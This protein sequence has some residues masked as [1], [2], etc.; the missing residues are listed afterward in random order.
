MLDRVLTYLTIVS[1][2]LLPLVASAWVRSYYTADRAVRA[3]NGWACVAG[4]MNG[5]VSLWVA[6]IAPDL[7]FFDYRR[8]QSFSGGTYQATFRRL[9]AKQR[10]WV[11][12]FGAAD[13]DRFPLRGVTTTGRA[14]GWVM[15]LWFPTLLCL[16]LPFRL[17]VRQA[18][19]YVPPER[20][21]EDLTVEIDEP[22]VP[23][24]KAAQGLSLGSALPMV[25][26]GVRYAGRSTQ[27]AWQRSRHGR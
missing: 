27:R 14:R 25:P 13:A 10:F 4:S 17:I 21:P 5:Q 23:R 22:A 26:V 11:L 12:G 2:L 1:A 20:R 6:P 7:R 8:R 18:Q 16:I 3:G 15:P 19:P 9:Q 24:S